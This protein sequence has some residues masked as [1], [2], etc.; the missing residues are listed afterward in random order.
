MKNFK[1][2]QLVLIK[3]LIISAFITIIIIPGTVFQSLIAEHQEK[4]KEEAHSKSNIELASF[5]K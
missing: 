4:Q 2:T 3:I 5:E 1:T